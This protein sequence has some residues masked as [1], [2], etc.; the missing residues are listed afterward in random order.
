MPLTV[1]RKRDFFISKCLENGEGWKGGRIKRKRDL[2]RE[3]S[4]PPPPPSNSSLELGIVRERRGGRRRSL[5]SLNF[6]LEFR[7][8]P[9][10]LLLGMDFARAR[11]GG[12]GGGGRG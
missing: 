8:L 11:G 2:L 10:R 7:M 4:P 3:I 12:G 6:N 5:H 9:A 1:S